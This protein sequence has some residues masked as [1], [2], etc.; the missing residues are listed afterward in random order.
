MTFYSLNNNDTPHEI[1]FLSITKYASGAEKISVLF[2]GVEYKGNVYFDAKGNRSFK[3]CGKTY[4]FELP[5]PGAR[6][7]SRGMRA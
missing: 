7:V 2:D 4:N 3:H 1:I 6:S 5:N